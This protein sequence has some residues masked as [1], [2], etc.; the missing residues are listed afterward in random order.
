MVPRSVLPSEM[1][2]VRLYPASEYPPSIRSFEE[3]T[4]LP[5]EWDVPPEAAA[6]EPWRVPRPLHSL[7]VTYAW[8][9][10]LPDLLTVTV[11]EPADAPFVYQTSTS[12]SSPLTAAVAF[13]QVLP[14]VSV[15]LV[16]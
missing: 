13:V 12:V 2:S 8:R 15:T 5:D 16:T 10:P 11:S 3:V 4:R 1:D 6:C 14:R 7:M 9:Y